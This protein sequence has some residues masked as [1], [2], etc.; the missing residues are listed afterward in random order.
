MIRSGTTGGIFY[1]QGSLPPL[2][3]SPPHVGQQFT[4]L[5]RRVALPPLPWT[6]KTKD[7]A[8]SDD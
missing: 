2:Q 6:Q 1:L 4:R 5:Q 3:A 7:I 8:R